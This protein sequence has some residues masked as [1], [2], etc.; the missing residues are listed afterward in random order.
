MKRDLYSNKDFTA[1]KE[2]LNQEILRRG[3]F[4][5]WDPL[6]QP[7]VGCDH[8]SPLSIPDTDEDRVLVDDKT[9]TINNPSEGSIERTRN[10]L[11]P[12]Q[13]E[14]PAGQ[15]PERLSTVP[16]TSASQINVDEMKN[17]LVGLSK[18]RDVN[19]FYGRDE[20][21]YL[22][23]RDPQGIEDAVAAAQESELSVPLHESD[24]PHVKNDP[25]GGMKDQKHPDYPV[26]NYPVEYP[27]E[28][29]KYVM[30]SGEMDGE[31]TSVYTPL[32]P[33]NFYDDYGANPGD[34]NFHPYNPFVPRVENRDWNDFDHDR[35]II[36]TKV[37]PG[38]ESSIRFGTNPR[39]PNP[40]NPY[41]S[42]P[43]YGGKKGSCENA[44]TGLCHVTCDNECGES[45]T[46]TCW[47]RCGNACTYNCG[48]NCTGCNSLCFNSCQTKCEN[49]TG[50]SCVKAGAK[51]VFI[52]TTGGKNGVPAKNVIRVEYHVCQGCSYSCQFYP[53]K[54]T[55]CWDSGCMGKCFITCMNTCSESCFGGCI[56]NKSQEGKSYKTGLGRG[57]MDG[58]TLNCI[59]LCSGTC[60]GYC[61]QTCW[62]ACKQLCSD[63]CSWTCATNCGNGCFYS[64]TNGCGG[65][66]SCSGSCIGKVY[67]TT[68]C[69]GCDSNGGCSAMCQHGCDKNCIGIGCRSICGTESSGACEANCRL[70][71]MGTS[72]TA[73]CSDACSTQCTTCVNNCGFQCGACSSLCALDCGA[74]CNINCTKTCEHS[75][76]SNCVHSCSEECG[77]CSDLCYSCVSMCIGVCSVKC[78]YM[79]SSC[80]NNCSWWCDSSCNQQCFGDCNSFCLHSCESSCSTHL[81]SSTTHT[82]GPERSPTAQGYIYPN[83]KNRWEERES[84]KIMRD[85]P[86]YEEPLKKEKLLTITFDQSR[87]LKLIYRGET[88]WSG[89][90]V[91]MTTITSGVF[92]INAD[93]GEITINED[94]LPGIVSV[95]QPNLNN[96]DE[97]FIITLFDPIHWEDVEVILPFGFTETFIP[98]S[99]GHIRV[100]IEYEKFLLPE[101]KQN[102]ED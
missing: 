13:G 11:Y 47:N 97:I 6:S 89:Y 80:A 12:A 96:G 65:C 74:S 70:S 28:N 22:A 45:C 55:E 46:T 86:T 26:Q 79:C 51:A 93:T 100:I 52:T 60:E 20:E 57:C 19:L 44:C 42:R 99:E 54:K 4:K 50:Y 1:L 85:I 29:G 84:F 69:A 40:G 92:N 88:P 24:N 76:E 102:G 15:D 23:Y 73:L 53:N 32:G 61:I 67:S 36:K 31:E 101:E 72:C 82:A 63:N 91:K 8:G 33:G 41:P 17:F 64:C 9:Y 68:T 16:N 3:T 35:N 75:C 56:D 38:G 48:N 5:Y 66:S 83:P 81:M 37:R 30:P 87:N 90:D 2:K 21:K 7:K 27:M 98:Y 18:I 59:G 43:V 14:N 58:C 94:M 77:G 49:I 39:N 10:I 62:H 71:C 78:E 25:N 34:S 95:N